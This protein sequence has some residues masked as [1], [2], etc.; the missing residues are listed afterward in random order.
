RSPLVVASVSIPHHAYGLGTLDRYLLRCKR[1]DKDVAFLWETK[2]TDFE[3]PVVSFTPDDS[4]IFTFSF[5]RERKKSY[6]SLL[7]ASTS[8]ER[9]RLEIP[10]SVNPAHAFSPNGDL[11]ALAI[12]DETTGVVD[13]R[14]GR[15]IA[16]LDGQQGPVQCLAFAADAANLFTAGS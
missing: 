3:I 6:A 12:A 10:L 7:E 1:S 16:T 13:V 11:L 5:S 9:W 15:V 14:S 4:A 8:K 2:E